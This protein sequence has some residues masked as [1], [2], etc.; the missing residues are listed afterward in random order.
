MAAN[1]NAFIVKTIQLKRND[2][3]SEFIAK[4]KNFSRSVMYLILKHCFET[5]EIKDISSNYDD[6]VSDM[7]RDCVKKGNGKSVKVAAEKSA[8]IGTKDSGDD[9]LPSCYM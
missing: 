8:E 6:L 2:I 4:Q 9:E 1:G 3:F 5:G 7:M